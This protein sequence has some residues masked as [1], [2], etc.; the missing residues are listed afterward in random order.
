VRHNPYPKG[1]FV[2]TNTAIEDQVLSELELDPRIPD[3]G[4]IAAAAVGDEVTLRGTVGS[5]S[6]RRAAVQDA[7]KVEGVGSVVDELKVDLLDGDHR[8]DN[9]I[10]GAALQMLILDVEVPSDYVSV[11]VED[12]WVTLKGD[13]DYQFQSDDAYDDV[14]SLYGVV[15]ITNEIR[16]TTP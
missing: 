13:V 7:R 2:L 12:G 15:G 6:Q 3:T 8:D 9:E 16:V 5:F 10:K 14:G 1:A 11:N 4:Q